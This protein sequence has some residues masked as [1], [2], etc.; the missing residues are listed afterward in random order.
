[1]AD[2]FTPS[3]DP[4]SLRC[5]SL[6]ARL[7]ELTALQRQKMNEVRADLAMLRKAAE[8]RLDAVLAP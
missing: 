6:P 8:S 5:G 1:M 7:E 3:D 4:T 2:P